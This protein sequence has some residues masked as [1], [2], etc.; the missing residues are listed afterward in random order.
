MSLYGY[1]GI[2]GKALQIQRLETNTRVE[3]EASREVVSRVRKCSRACECQEDS[4]VL[5]RSL[6]AKTLC[7][8]QFHHLY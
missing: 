8:L 5:S 2:L 6:K 1:P 3:T 4:Q 7:V